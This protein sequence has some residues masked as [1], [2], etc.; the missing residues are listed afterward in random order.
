MPSR[1]PSILVVGAG[2]AG[3]TAAI[4]LRRRGFAPRI[5]EQDKG[6]H[7]ESRAIAINPRSLDILQPSGATSR[8]LKR[9]IK[10]TATNIHGPRGVM[11]RLDLK[12]MPHKRRY[13]LALPQAD[14]EK[15]LI[16]TLGGRRMIEWNTRL[17]ALKRGKNGNSA[18]VMKAGRKRVIKADIVI[19]ADGAH[20]TTR[21]QL[22]IGFA[23]AAYEH[24]WSLAD[25]RVS[26]PM[27]DKEL[28][29]FDTR[30]ELV[31]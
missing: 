24:D 28:H 9:G 10:L 6:P 31:A 14:T 22:G 19:G 7:V 16:E 1:K 11:I 27:S 18:T 15:V 17:V 2:P 26:G 25:I 29:A 3:L 21:K 8:L 30:P 12:N 20:S 23:G 5:I 13:M 4:E